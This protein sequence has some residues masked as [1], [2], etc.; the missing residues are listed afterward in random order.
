MNATNILAPR[1]TRYSDGSDA[2]PAALRAWLFE[3]EQA[4]DKK[5]CQH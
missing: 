1:D 5:R 2:P 4:E 3:A